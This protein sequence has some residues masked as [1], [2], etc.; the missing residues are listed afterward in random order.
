MKMLN[1]SIIS[2]SDTKLNG[3]RNA[4][5]E[6]MI[7]RLLS[8]LG[9]NIIGLHIYPSDLDYFP[10]KD[11]L[12]I[13]NLLI[14][15]NGVGKL[16]ILKDLGNSIGLDL[17]KIDEAF[18]H[19]QTRLFES[20]QDLQ[21]VYSVNELK[22]YEK[23]AFCLESSYV[24]QNEKG[25]LPGFFIRKDSK[26]IVILPEEDES[27][28]SILDE[29]L[30]YYL[31]NIAGVSFSTT[32][33]LK[34]RGNSDIFRSFIDEMNSLPVYLEYSSTRNRFDVVLKIFSKDPEDIDKFLKKIK[35]VVEKYSD[36]ADID[37]SF[38]KD[39]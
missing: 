19:I 29:G 14:V 20:T 4:T 26:F 7:S 12:D 24:L 33:N 1:A 9:F 17:V 5:T 23:Y 30:E 35:D 38:L 37:A 11:E 25:L 2:L 36:K 10:L 8:K 32:V 15:L 13:S 27:I 28:K 3:L 21:K 6:A 18:E 22:K 34:F 16:E 31:R 39:M